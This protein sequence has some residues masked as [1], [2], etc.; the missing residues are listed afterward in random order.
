[1]L[2]GTFILNNSEYKFEISD[3]KIQFYAE[4]NNYLYC[5]NCNNKL[6]TPR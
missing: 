2:Q 3:Y 4:S 6:D 5:A 1:M